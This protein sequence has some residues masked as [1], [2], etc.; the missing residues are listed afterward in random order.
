MGRSRSLDE[1][2]E[3]P[4]TYSPVGASAGDLP[5]GYHHLVR[6]RIV[7][8]GHDDFQAGAR[9]VLAWAAQRGSGVRVEASSPQARPGTA[10]MLRVGPG[11]LA[12]VAP[13]RV[14]YVIEEPRRRGFAYGTLSGHPV[15]GE[16]A[17]LVELR[18]DG[19]VVFTVKAYSRPASLL[20]RVAGPLNRV[21]Q[22]FMAGRYLA[23][24]HR[25]VQ[26]RR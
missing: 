20:T 14:V 10:L 5:R 21:L 25:V 26:E 19:D 2:H 7:G 22:R 6:T 3:Q 8:H 12:L 1:L 23:A 13:A 9:A 11:R 18:P 16:E 4:F 15:S 24:V 17:F